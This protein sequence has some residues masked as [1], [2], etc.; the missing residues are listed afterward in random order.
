LLLIRDLP[1]V[2]G[3]ALAKLHALMPG[4]PVEGKLHEGGT[5]FWSFASLLPQDSSGF[6]A[7]AASTTSSR[8]G[9]GAAGAAA[10]EEEDGAAR[11]QQPS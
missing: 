10:A 3:T 7:A 1:A 6:A 11:A 2:V 8:G 5:V 9:A 4:I